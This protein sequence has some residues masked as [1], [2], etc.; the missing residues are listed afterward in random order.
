MLHGIEYL[1][2]LNGFT[3]ILRLIQGLSEESATKSGVLIIPIVPKSLEERDEALL[4]SET[5][6]MPMPASS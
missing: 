3:P 6:P 5:T 1:T 4:V 2:T